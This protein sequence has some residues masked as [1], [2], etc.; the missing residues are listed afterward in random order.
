MEEET[1][2]I[3]FHIFHKKGTEVKIEA[4][5]LQ[6]LLEKQ[7]PN[8]EKLKSQVE[9]IG[10]KV[11]TTLCLYDPNSREIERKISDGDINPFG[12]RMKNQ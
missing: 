8:K 4:K 5:N 2:Q 3:S 7:F 6:E 9:R 10:W 1:K 11:K 12:W